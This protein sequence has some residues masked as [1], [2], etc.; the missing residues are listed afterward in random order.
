MLP[1]SIAAFAKTAIFTTITCYRFAALATPAFAVIGTL[2][3]A[4]A[5]ISG[6]R[7]GSIRA[8][9]GIVPIAVADFPIL[10]TVAH[11]RP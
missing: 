8:I 5:T 11:V 4:L 2:I 9:G 10:S 6:F 1:A 3:A 7:R